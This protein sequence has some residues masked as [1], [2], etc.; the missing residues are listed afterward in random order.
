MMIPI[1]KPFNLDIDVSGTT[2]IEDLTPENWNLKT[3]LMTE[4][5]FNN[6]VVKGVADL[7]VDPNVEDFI[8]NEIHLS[9][10]SIDDPVIKTV[11]HAGVSAFASPLNVAL[12]AESGSGKSYSTTETIKFLPQD[13]VQFIGSQSPK[14]ISHLNG[15]RK[16]ADGRLFDSIPEPIKPDKDDTD[17]MLSYK[18]AYAIYLEQVKAYNELKDNCIYEI[19]LRNKI[20]L[21]L[22]SVD[23]ATF[24]MYK[25][26]MSHDHD[27]VDHP[28]VDDN[29]KVHYTRLLGAPVLI[30][31]S[32]DSFYM[33]EFA[34]R[35]LTLSPVTT[36]EK[37]EASMKISNRKSC[38][39]WL[40]ASDT[41]N[42]AIIQKYVAKIRDTMQKGRIRTINPFDGITDLFSKSQTR[43]MRDFNKYLELLPT[44]AIVKLFQRPVIVL[45]GHRYLVPTMQD[46]YTAKDL[47]DSVVETTQTGTEKRIMQFYWSVVAKLDVN[48]ATLETL[49][50]TYNNDPAHKKRP[51]SSHRIRSWLERL[52][53]IEFVD[54]RVGEQV[55][56]KGDVDRQKIT[57]HPLKL[58]GNDTVLPIE[59]DL[60][61][62]L[63]KAFETWLKTCD[64]DIASHP[65]MILN[66]NDGAVEINLEEF[67]D[68]I[69][70]GEAS[71]M[72]QV[73][74]ANPTPKQETDPLNNSIAETKQDSNNI[75]M[76]Y[77][78]KLT[79]GEP[80]RCDGESVGAQCKETAKYKML[81]SAD[82]THYCETHFQR[83]SNDCAS[84]S[85]LLK[86]QIEPSLA[87]TVKPTLN[88]QKCENC[89]ALASEYELIDSR[90]PTVKIYVCG[91]CLHNNVIPNYKAQ[92]AKIAIENPEPT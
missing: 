65:I 51:M 32:V 33:A 27:F 53:E 59:Q 1:E 34:T 20:T 82:P 78:R 83:V 37:F 7:S 13:V 11:F 49:T 92:N 31:N 19:D 68:I 28:W 57:Y 50:N 63:E 21:F 39:P 14:V 40:F 6:A 43:D 67:A 77:Y 61:D 8:F 44:Y 38:Y 73:L 17:P 36:P 71:I 24:K 90:N 81:S 2:P 62:I 89:A 41:L 12:K 54:S 35:T 25:A 84:N 52:E 87:I 91:S 64:A 55:T 69:R 10:S 76:L 3:S 80:Y 88:A 66:V 46:F 16:T 60:K 4:T 22:E 30:F 45:K 86:E 15:I 9:V 29:G 56:A 48:G 5:A 47:Y 72:S 26:T 74:K 58:K 75:Q 18:E 42:R 85:F 23:P 79:V 70:G